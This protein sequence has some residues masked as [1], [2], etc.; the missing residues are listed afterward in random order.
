MNIL[1]SVLEIRAGPVCL[2]RI[3]TEISVALRW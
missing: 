1:Q 2:D 3:A